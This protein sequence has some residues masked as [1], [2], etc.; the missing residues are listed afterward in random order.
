MG[1]ALAESCAESGAEVI[2]ISGPVN[3]STR[4][5]AI[6]RIDVES[7]EEM[8]KAATEFY[9]AATLASYVQL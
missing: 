7:A 5:P 2:L 1:Y 6:R 8:Y 4:H 3:L 9:P